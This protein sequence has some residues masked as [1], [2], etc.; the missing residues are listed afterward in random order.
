MPSKPRTRCSYAG[1]NAKTVSHGR[2]AEHQPPAWTRPSAH[3][4][5]IGND[6]RRWRRVRAAV[7]ARDGNACRQCGAHA[8]QVDHIVA[9]AD[10]GAVWDLNNLQSLCSTCH[11]RKTLRER[12]ERH[13]KHVK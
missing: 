4:L 13:C 12:Y 8:T 5:A 9:I 3:T 11:A 2:C 10:G 7:L 1:C 6:T